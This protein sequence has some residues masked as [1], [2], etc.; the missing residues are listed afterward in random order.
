MKKCEAL[1][2][3][4]CSRHR[5]CFNRLYVKMRLLYFKNLGPW[6]LEKVVEQKT[7][8]SVN[9]YF[10]Y[11]SHSSTSS[12]P[13]YC[14]LT[15]SG[16]QVVIECRLPYMYFSCLVMEEHVV[17]LTR[18]GVNISRG[19]DHQTSS[20]SAPVRLVTCKTTTLCKYSLETHQCIQGAQCIVQ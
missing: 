8:Y 15:V 13:R 12:H 9:S 14:L 18:N 5:T 17:D 6:T 1:G 3:L 2:Y 10:S 20:Q 16:S 19:A 7:P 11:R 4:T